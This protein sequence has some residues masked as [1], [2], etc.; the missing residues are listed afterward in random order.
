MA[1]CSYTCVSGP[2]LPAVCGYAPPP[3]QDG[4]DIKPSERIAARQVADQLDQQL[5]AELASEG[6]DVGAAAAW[7]DDSIKLDEAGEVAE[8]GYVDENGELRRPWCPATRILEHREQV[9]SWQAFGEHCRR[10]LHWVDASDCC[11]RCLPGVWLHAHAVCM[12]VRIVW[13][14]TGAPCMCLVCMRMHVGAHA[15]ACLTRVLSGPGGHAC[16]QMVGVTA[17]IHEATQ[18]LQ[19][20]GAVATPGKV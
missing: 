1:R 13:D 16:H 15:C 7:E 4:R 2:E 20:P 5:R 9:T 11:C 8:T 17:T 6:V 10:I 3:K 14:C 19:P 18:H 12:Q